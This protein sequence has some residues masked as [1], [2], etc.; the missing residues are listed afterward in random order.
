[1]AKDEKSQAEK[2]LADA[3]RERIAAEARAA[4]AQRAQD[5]A[6]SDVPP[7]EL[8]KRG[9]RAEPKYA[10]ARLVEDA[11]DL[12]AAPAFALVGALHGV[13]SEYLTIDEAR[14]ALAR[15]YGE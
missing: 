6:G 9:G 11:S 2:A 1:V 13:D 15:Y 10:R 14:Q 7:P 3:E 12:F 5:K 4:E 8:P